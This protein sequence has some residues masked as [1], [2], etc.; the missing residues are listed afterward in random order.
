[1][2][3]K[4]R[5]R[6][7]Q[8]QKNSLQLKKRKL[9]SQLRRRPTRHLTQLQLLARKQRKKRLV[10]ERLLLQP[11]PEDPRRVLNLLNRLKPPLRQRMARVVPRPQK[12]IRRKRL[13]LLMIKNQKM[14]Q[15][16]PSLR[17]IPP[18]TA[19]D[20]K[21]TRSRLRL[22]SLTRRSARMLQLTRIA[23]P[24]LRQRR[25]PPIQTPQT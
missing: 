9:M 25:Q 13:R 22:S 12:R 4:E 10:Q 15:S 19:P 21:Q 16:P 18:R 24:K 11:S 20:L 6:R 7:L 14:L 17:Q 3:S 8:L 2:T 23:Q 1:M 5:R